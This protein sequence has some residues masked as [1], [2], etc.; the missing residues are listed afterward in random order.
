ME[1]D[2]SF[3]AEILKIKNLNPNWLPWIGKDF[4]LSQNKKRLLV[5]G[6][7]CYIT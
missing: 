7:S 6:E 5:I 1:I 2:K 4:N 3:D